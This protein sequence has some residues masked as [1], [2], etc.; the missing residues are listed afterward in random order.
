MSITERMLGLLGKNAESR[1]EVAEEAAE[2]V[3]IEPTS[4]LAYKA[5]QVLAVGLHSDLPDDPAAAE[6]LLGDL[7]KQLRS[8][9][10][11][12]LQKALRRMSSNSRAQAVARNIKKDIS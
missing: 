2:S 6:D 5:A 4:D 3:A 9:K 8:S 1:E 10:K 7:M 11:V 12:L